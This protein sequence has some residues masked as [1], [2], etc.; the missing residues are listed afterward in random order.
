MISFQKL[1]ENYKKV[2]SDK[3]YGQLP[4]MTILELMR[5]FEIDY[6]IWMA[7]NHCDSQL[8]SLIWSSMTL[9]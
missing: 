8:K 3:K 6:D 7:W 5:K 4:K 2:R 1:K 9:K